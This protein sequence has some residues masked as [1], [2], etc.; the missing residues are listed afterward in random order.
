MAE[1][2]SLE[3]INQFLKEQKID[4]DNAFSILKYLT[5]I[6]NNRNDERLHETVLRVI[7]QRNLFENYQSLIN[8]LARE[9]GLFPY[10]NPTNLNL[11]D[12]IAYEFH[13]PEGLSESKVV[14]HR[15]QALVYFK[16]LDGK[17]VILSASTSFGKSLL[18][19]TIIAT[20]RYKNIAIVLPTIALIDETRKDFRSSKTYI[21]LLLTLLKLF[22]R[23]IFLF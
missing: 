23:I 10:L 11:A 5:T 9:V 21:S 7:E 4:K 19:D 20:K 2:L 6:I 12:K 3:A 17:N 16:L 8:D 14:L 13:K 22:K 15:V 1:D 18:I